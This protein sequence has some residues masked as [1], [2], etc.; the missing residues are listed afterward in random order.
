MN[1]ILE[2]IDFLLETQAELQ[3][4]PLFMPESEE[5]YAEAVRDKR[6]SRT[7]DNIDTA[8]DLPIYV[9]NF[10]GSKQHLTDWIWKNTPEGLK[11]VLDAFTGSA[12]V[13]Y[14]YKQKGL[15]VVCND[16]LRYCYHTARAII[17]NNSVTLSED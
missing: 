13:G 6:I 10:I 8:K 12:V 2:N 1:N 17:E 16:R 5:M 11:S 14:I 3:L 4:M 15:R 7:A 9:T